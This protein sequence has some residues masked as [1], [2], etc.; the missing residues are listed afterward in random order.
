MVR[1]ILGVVVGFIVGMVIT[2]G[3]FFGLWFALGVDG[4]LQKGEFKGTMALNIG[5]P[6][7]SVLGGLVGGLV[8]AKIGRS[9]KAVM[10][11]T[12]IML[13]LLAFGGWT[14][15]ARPNPGPRPDGLSV[16][17]AIM[18]NKPPMWF[19][20]L[21]PLI[22]AGAVFIGGRPGGG[23]MRGALPRSFGAEFSGGSG[24]SV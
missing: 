24:S 5:A 6:L 14:D 10:A 17:D 19:S 8:C 21:N 22:S 4:V 20:I 12:L 11:L 2:A 1:A 16:M 7:S 18:K 9:S 15:Q 23:V 13:V 3:L